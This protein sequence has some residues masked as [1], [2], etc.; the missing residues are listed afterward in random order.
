M[1][2]NNNIIIQ[3][4][5]SSSTFGRQ[6][7]VIVVNAKERV[8]ILPDGGGDGA[9]TGRIRLIST[10]TLDYLGN[11]LSPVFN[12]S[13]D[14]LGLNLNSA[15]LEIDTGNRLNVIST[16]GDAKFVRYDNNTQGLTT[17]QQTNVRTNIDF[18]ASVSVNASVSANTSA[19]HSHANITIL[20]GIT[21][22][23]S[24]IIISDAERTKLAGLSSSFEF[25]GSINVS[26]DFPTTAAVQNGHSYLIATA[27]TDNDATKTNTGQT[28]TAGEII[29]WNGTNWTE[30]FVGTVMSVNGM[31][32]N[33]VLTTDNVAEG[34]TNQYFTTARVNAAETDPTVGSHIKAITTTNISN[35]NTAFGWGDHSAAGYITSF[36]ETD[37]TVGSHIKAIT[38]T[39][40][41]N[42]NTAFGWGDHSA[43]G[44]ITSATGFALLTSPNLFT[45]TN[46]FQQAG[47]SKII[48]KDTTSGDNINYIEFQQGDGTLQ[49]RLGMNGNNLRFVDSSSNNRTVYHSGNLNL[50]TVDFSARNITSF[51][52]LNVQS[53]VNVTGEGAFI[54]PST[55]IRIDNAA[56]NPTRRMRFGHWD[57]TNN[58]IESNGANMFITAFGGD[59][60]MGI[61]GSIDLNINANGISVTGR[62]NTDTLGINRA[63]GGATAIFSWA[64]GQVAPELDIGMRFRG[65]VRVGSTSNN[66]GVIFGQSEGEADARWI[67]G[68]RAGIDANNNND[69]GLYARHGRVILWDANVLRAQTTAGGFSV[70][71][72]YSMRASSTTGR[73]GMLYQNNVGQTRWYNALDTDANGGNYQISRYND[74][75]TFVDTPFEII[76]SSG[77]FRCNNG[78]SITGATTSTG[79]GRFS[80]IL[81]GAGGNEINTTQPSIAINHRNGDGSNTNFRDFSV[82]DGKGADIAL[83]TGSTK[84]TSL[85]GNLSVTGNIT[86]T[87][88]VTATVAHIPT[89][90]ATGNL[91]LSDIPDSPSGLGAGDVWRDGT[92]LRIV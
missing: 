79:V 43:A 18:D 5:V 50:S 24:G 2:T 20:N 37:P 1:G 17:A 60:N 19:R 10:D 61:A 52:S 90:V 45:A 63:G 65:N 28:F 23:G 86:T 70:I 4:P 39:N 76:R 41:S 47:D 57:G 69:L 58:R 75:G 83:F 13:G 77:L 68:S 88:S 72:D 21:N 34:S 29:A 48:L 89:G 82:R 49:G 54:G 66:S 6:E 11:K 56:S 91:N 8:L 22:V 80:G 71:G 84:A 44:Y 32:G 31:Q 85:A 27:V 55:S 51:G 9:E 15:S 38:T 26:G 87:G 12:T 7:E 62:T 42:W 74:A 64:S 3:D 67:I 81:V 30:L 92:N 53:G 36:S 59:I 33:V 46:T 25:Q 14:R 78:I 40:I 73:W 16:F 35:W